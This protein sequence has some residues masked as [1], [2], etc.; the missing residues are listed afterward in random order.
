MKPTTDYSEIHI[1]FILRTEDD[2]SYEK[3]FTM[4]NECQLQMIQDMYDEIFVILTHFVDYVCV[5]A[6]TERDYVIEE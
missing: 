4:T 3:E 6:E 1:E 5:E 2:I